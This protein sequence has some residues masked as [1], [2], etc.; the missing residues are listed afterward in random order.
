M[1]CRHLVTK[2]F[3][4]G[5]V[6][7]AI[8]V[9]NSPVF[10]KLEKKYG[11]VNKSE[12]TQEIIKSFPDRISFNLNLEPLKSLNQD[13]S[14]TLISDSICLSDIFEDK[15][16]IDVFRE[17]YVNMLRHLASSMFN[18][19]NPLTHEID[20]S[21][22]DNLSS[23]ISLVVLK[24]VLPPQLDDD[25]NTYF[26]PT[27][28]VTIA[29]FL[30]SINAIKNGSNSNKNRRKSIDNISNEEDFFNEGYQSCLRGYSSPFFN[31]Y[32]REELMKPLTR[33]EL[34]YITVVCWRDFIDKF[35]TVFSDSTKLG[36]S[37]DWCNMK[38]VLSDFHDGFSYKVSKRMIDSNKVL[39]IDIKDYKEGSMTDLLNKVKKG[40][41]PIPYPMFM[42]LLELYVLQVF[43][44]KDL[45]LEPLKEVSREELAYYLV[46][47]ARVIWG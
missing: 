37:F 19:N 45:R 10:S 38:D 40:V 9:S 14:D 11:Q 31:L 1:V 26:N 17:E 4:W 3:D 35:N 25:S 33:L 32:T 47:I 27:G 22:D 12:Y 41:V 36:I 43:Y 42:C 7:K 23:Y 34:G 8:I 39:S 20:V 29:E 28:N 21:E 16:Q 30:D 5:L 18:G 13:L 2:G 44:F 15:Q 6:T 46:N 24:G